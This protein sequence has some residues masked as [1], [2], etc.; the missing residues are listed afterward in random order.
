MTGAERQRLLV[1][2]GRTA[3]AAGCDST[4]TAA[5]RVL[6]EG[7][8]A[9]AAGVFERTDAEWRVRALVGPDVESDRAVGTVVED[10]AGCDLRAAVERGSPVVIEDPADSSFPPSLVA[11]AEGAMLCAPVDG[12]GVVAVFDSDAAAF[13]EATQTFATHVADLIAPA[14]A[15]GAGADGGP[16]V[17]DLVRAVLRS[18]AVGETSERD[19]VAAA[20]CSSLADAPAFDAAV[21]VDT[22]PVSDTV[23]V[24]ATAGL[25]EAAADDLLAGEEV[26]DLITE[27]AWDRSVAVEDGVSVPTVDGARTVV[28]TPVDYQDRSYGVLLLVAH[29]SGLGDAVRAAP[30]GDAAPDAILDIARLAGFAIHAA[31]NREAYRSMV[32]E[33]LGG[34]ADVGVFVLDEENQVAWANETVMNYFALDPSETLGADK[35]RL[36]QDRVVQA[37][38]NPGRFAEGL[39]EI[40]EG[41][42]GGNVE[43]DVS[44]IEG[45]GR[46]A[47]HLEHRSRPIETGLYA[48]GR[49]ELYYDVTDRVESE[50]AVREHE[51]FQSTLLRNL[52]GVVYRNR[53]EPGWPMEFVSEGVVDLT[54]YEADDLTAGDV[55]WSTDVIHPEDQGDVWQHVGTIAADESAGDSPFE[56]TYRIRT[57]EGDVKW[58]WERGHGVYEDGALVAI[59]GFVTDVTD[60]QESTVELE[61]QRD[62]LRRLNRINTVIRRTQR[63]LVRAETLP[64]VDT[65]VCEG[66]VEASPYTLVWTAD[67][68]PGS[69]RMTVREARGGDPTPSESFAESGPIWQAVVADEPAALAD[70]SDLGVAGVPDGP[71]FVVP[72]QFSEANH[73]VLVVHSDDADLFDDREREV[74]AELGESIA[75]ARSALVRKAGL[76]GDVSTE[77]ELHIADAF[78]DGFALDSDATGEQPRLVVE[79][80]VADGD[81][82]IGYLRGESLSIE[83]FEH[84]IQQLPNVH[85]MTRLAD[86]DDGSLRYKVIQESPPLASMLADNGGRIRSMTI[87]G[88]DVSLQVELPVDVAVRDVVEG[89]RKIYPEAEMVA[90]RSIAE[91]DSP[92][93][94]RHA[95]LETL[96]DRQ[97]T[98]L[99]IAYAS[100]YFEWPRDQTA[101]EVAETLGVSGPTLSQHLRHAERKVFRALFD[102]PDES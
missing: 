24:R 29:S 66:L 88:R 25:S 19:D 27:T 85:S 50:L 96:T 97:R 18:V 67:I 80:T 6:V 14:V 9:P 64:E 22:D 33:V 93:E 78:P 83:S 4:V 98:A 48:G 37:V 77:L 92:R 43:F 70:A 79:R 12:W 31:E 17:D 59:E 20:L 42:G 15:A 55:D 65:A 13:D 89:T 56:I 102:S 32:E 40:Y 76:L 41:D 46:P 58:V 72:L 26:T 30:T 90:Q 1:D 52:P 62:E 44:I 71:V 101:E 3:Q 34:A 60:R 75:H 82:Y 7:T 36:V 11:A 69:R 100:G 94:D 49:V 47:R 53:N 21:L 61:R 87:E 51:L 35:R 38:E 16:A 57:R 68:H 86:A 99:E 91:E 23:D 28:V 73:G 84:S 81:R 8:D 74:L 95:A 2:L 63:A 10:P 39:L 5:A 45:S 54:G